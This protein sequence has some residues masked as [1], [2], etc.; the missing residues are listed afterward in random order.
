[1]LERVDQIPNR[2]GQWYT[3][4]LSFRDRPDEQFTIYHRDPVNA[5]K[6]LWGDPSFSNDLVYKPARLFRGSDQREEHRIFSEMWTGGFWNA[7]Q[8]GTS[9]Q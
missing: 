4:R 1:M 7:A 8:V 2:G 5:I 6:A 3:K 9:I